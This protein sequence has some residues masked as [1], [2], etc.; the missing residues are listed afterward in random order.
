MKLTQ[1]IDKI[2]GVKNSKPF[3]KFDILVY[4]LTLA[5]ILALFIF[6]VILPPKVTP[7]GFKVL[8]KGEILFTF[9][10]HSGENIADGKGA[11]IE[12]TLDGNGVYFKV[13]LDD[14]KTEYNVI[15]ADTLN[16]LVKMTDSNCSNHKDCVYSPSVS[17]K[18]A[19]LCAPHSLKIIPLGD[20]R[21]PAVTG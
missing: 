4:S 11:F 5:V 19:I 16:L 2:N 6:A 10:Y 8:V 9:D 13:Y 21:L 17:D 1:N 12:K 18:G 3:K 20:E 14:D 15:F 7:S